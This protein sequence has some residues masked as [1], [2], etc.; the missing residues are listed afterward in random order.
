LALGIV[1][2]LG[3][4]L[5]LGQVLEHFLFQVAPRDPAVLATAAAVMAAAGALACYT[6]ARRAA[7]LDPLVALRRE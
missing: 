7:R 2:G 3:A 5:A 1:I 4:A 6:P